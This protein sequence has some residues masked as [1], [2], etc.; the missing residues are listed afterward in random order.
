MMRSRRKE[1]SIH[2]WTFFHLLFAG[3]I[4]LIDDQHV[5]E[6]DLPKLKLFNR[7]VIGMRED[8]VCVDNADDAVQPKAIPQSRIGE[9]DGDARGIRDTFAAQCSAVAS[10][11]AKCDGF[12]AA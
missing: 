11:S 8:L 9:R 1:L 6:A 10:S 5:G 12:V 4:D 2:S 7:W 3:Q